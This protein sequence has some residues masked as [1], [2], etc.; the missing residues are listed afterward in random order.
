MT[1]RMILAVDRGNAI[2]WQDGHLPWKIPADIKRFKE[3][4]IG[5]DVIM[6]RKTFDSLGRPDGL[7]N[8]FNVV[9]T[10]NLKGPWS[11][12]VRVTNTFADYVKAH[13]EGLGITPKDL[14][15]IG[16]AQIYHQAISKQLV[17]EIHLTLVDTNSGADVTLPFDLS[18]W[19]L[20]IMR[21]HK[22]GVQWNLNYLSVPQ[23]TDA[24]LS[25][26]FLTLKKTL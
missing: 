11:D 23:K 18:A 6:G 2:G 7:P 16:G 13:Q 14:W 12:K 3:L 21:Q 1:V 19:K 24:G 10:R 22:D 17:D 25:F 26:I 9:V 20:F 4:T 15:I 8:R 5:H